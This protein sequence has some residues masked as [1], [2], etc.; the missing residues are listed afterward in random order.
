MAQQGTLFREIGDGLKAEG[1]GRAQFVQTTHA[2]FPLT[3]CV[4]GDLGNFGTW[5]EALA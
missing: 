2:R 1:R 4:N 5:P 3:D